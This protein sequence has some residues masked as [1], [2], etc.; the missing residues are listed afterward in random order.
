MSR[1]YKTC[2]RFDW[3]LIF[4]C[5]FVVEIGTG[6]EIR[7]G[8]DLIGFDWVLIGEGPDGFNFVSVLWWES[9]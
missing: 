9:P 5:F 1:I 2:L 7:L 4:G 3:V 6:A 8:K